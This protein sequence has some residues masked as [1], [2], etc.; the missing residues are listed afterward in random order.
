[1][2]KFGLSNR[3]SSRQNNRVPNKAVKLPSDLLTV[4]FETMPIEPRPHYPPA[5]VGVSL[6]WGSKAPKYLAY[7]HPTKNNTTWKEAKKVLKAEIKKAKHLVFHNS[8]F[9]VEILQEEFGI[10]PEAKLHDTQ[11]LLFLDDPHQLQIGL[12]ESAERLLGEPPGERDA[13]IDWLVAK[14]PI[15]G[16]KITPKKGGKNYAGKYI[17]YAP[18]D[19]VGKYANG[20]TNRTYKLFKLLYPWIV[21]QGMG[22]AYEREIALMPILM[23]LEQ[24]GVNVD[25]ERLAREVENYEIWAAMIESWVIK[26][27]ACPPDTNLNSPKEFTNA[28]TASGFVDESKMERTEKTGKPSTAKGSLDAAVTDKQLRAVLRYRSQL[29][30]CLSTFMK[31]WLESA[32]ASGGKIYTQWNQTK[33]ERGKVTMGTRTGR[34]SS[35]KPNFLNIPNTFQPLFSDQAKGKG[36][37]RRPIKGLPNLPVVRGYIIPGEG[38]VF[39]DRDYSQQEPRTLAHFDGGKILEIYQRNPWADVHDEAQAELAKL[40][41]NFERKPIKI[42]NLG[43]IYAKGIPLLAKE[44]DLPKEV[45][46]ELKET[47]LNQVFP[48]VKKMYADMANRAAKGQPAR[49]WGGR[50]IYC[51]KPSKVNGEW[52]TWEYKMVNHLIQGSAADITKEA[53]IRVYR[54]FKSINPEWRMELQ[55][56]DQIL[57]SAPVEDLPEAMEVQRLQMESIETR[58]PM[59]SEG[60]IS[61]T[62][63]GEMITYDKKG[64]IEYEK[65]N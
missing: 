27:L 7:G 53:M 11:F 49:T 44:T 21:S 64:V 36:L 19:L 56:Y 54:A 59:L 5:S 50:L 16:I 45:A 34:P 28:L 4:D 22:A 2:R 46:K 26:K 33:V 43:I 39:I 12:K 48:G 63:W 18:G 23:E 20:D 6:K 3:D 14:Q 38:R 58:V 8:K 37:P 32:Q 13:V 61:L 51:E 41:R 35:T 25:T 65:S 24:Q 15:E 30:T 17:G 9:D 31:P 40:G 57:S 62:N 60:D 29:Q 52:R 55:V 10:Y 1:M 42:I 47:I